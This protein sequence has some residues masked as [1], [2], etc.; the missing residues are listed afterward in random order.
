MYATHHQDLFYITVKCTII[1]QRVIKNRADTILHLK[2]SRGN[3]SESMKARVVILVR[4][5]TSRPVLR[6]CEVS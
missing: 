4:N 1:N 5:T 3:N 2:Q 6:N